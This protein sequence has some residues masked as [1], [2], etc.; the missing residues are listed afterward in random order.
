MKK[1][2][3]DDMSL[4]VAVVQAGSLSQAAELTGIPVSRLS[5]RLTE[6]ERA[7]GTQL[8]NR[9]KKGVRLNELGQGFF[10]HAQTMLQQAQLA[11][12][13]VQHGLE[14]PAGLLRMSVAADIYHCVLADHLPGYLDAHPEVQLEIHLTH[15]K[16]NMIQ[17]GIDVAIRVG[18][19]DNENVVARRLF[20]LQFGIYA[21][22]A[23]LQAHGRP[24]APND[25]YRHHTISQMLTLPWRFRWQQHKADI[26]PAARV[27]CQD[28]LSAAR[29]MAQG[30]GIGMLPT[31]VAAH[32]PTLLRVLDDWQMPEV[33]VSAVYY[34]NRGAT[35][36]VRSIVDWA[37]GIGGRSP[38]APR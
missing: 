23:Y 5:R 7:L 4:F 13:S 21:S 32:Q 29:L 27:A 30:L 31:A 9:G 24:Q 16:I 2:S 15:K 26:Q 38:W 12:D 37:A 6:L 10:Q 11:L 36:L 28:F 22:A 20:V 33:P 1:A 17:E 34:R 35:P 14:R 3:L 19:I 18:T 8:L 25:L